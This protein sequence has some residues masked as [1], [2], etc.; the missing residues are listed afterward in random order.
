MALDLAALANGAAVTGASNAFYSN[1]VG[2]IMPGLPASQ[3]DGWETARRREPGHEWLDVRLAGRGVVRVAELDTTH[4]KHNAPGWASIE[5][6]DGDTAFV[7]SVG[8]ASVPG[9]V[10]VVG[11]AAAEVTARAI[12]RGARLAHGLPGLP[13][14][15]DLARR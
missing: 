7:L 12:L 4:L 14:A 2:A 15:A 5:A 10:L 3:A 1:P 8:S 9:G 6:H 11:A 13:A